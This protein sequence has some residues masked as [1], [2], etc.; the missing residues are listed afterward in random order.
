[1]DNRIMKL[2]VV[3]Y[4]YYTVEDRDNHRPS[5]CDATSKIYVLDVHYPDGM[6]PCFCDCD[7]PEINPTPTQIEN[8]V[9]I[10]IFEHEDTAKAYAYTLEKDEKFQQMNCKLNGEIY[11]DEYELNYEMTLDEIAEAIGFDFD[12]K[13]CECC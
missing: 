10:G 6:E 9:T 12:K 4:V 13:C 2:W 5:G 8:T 7:K 11:I 3:N 1:M